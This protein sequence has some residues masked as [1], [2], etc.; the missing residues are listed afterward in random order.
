MD[1]IDQVTRRKLEQVTLGFIAN[2]NI[3]PHEKDRTNHALLIIS[4]KSKIGSSELDEFMLLVH[5]LFFVMRLKACIPVYHERF[6][7]F[8]DIEKSMCS[9]NFTS[10][11]LADLGSFLKYHMPYTIENFYIYGN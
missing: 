4:L 2:G 5:A 9:V 8:L 7:V 11:F 3:Y 10:K 1:F 6:S